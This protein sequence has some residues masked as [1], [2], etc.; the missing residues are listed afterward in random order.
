MPQPAP[1]KGGEKMKAFVNTKYKPPDVLEL[2]EKKTYV[3]GQ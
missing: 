3:Q 2:K 1:Y